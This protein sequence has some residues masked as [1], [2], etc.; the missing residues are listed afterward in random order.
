MKLGNG[1]ERNGRQHCSA[2]IPIDAM[3]CQTKIANTI[4]EKAGNSIVAVQDNQ[5]TL[6]QDIREYCEGLV[7]GTIRDLPEDGWKT[8]EARTHGSV[9][10][11]ELRTITDI[12]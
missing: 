8:E 9:E 5:K 3:G 11:R 7:Q 10:Q 12:R 2:R 1:S 4:R 6:H